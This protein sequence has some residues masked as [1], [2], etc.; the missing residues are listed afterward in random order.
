MSSTSFN[1]LLQDWTGPFGLPPFAAIEAA[2]FQPAFEQALAQ[3]RS[4][5]DAIA[6]QAEAPT[7]ANTL[8]AF[9]RSGRLLTRLEHLF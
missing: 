7:F 2:H 6:G 5:L 3:H 4:E 9:D 8:A 1:P